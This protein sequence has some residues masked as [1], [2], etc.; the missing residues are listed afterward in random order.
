MRKI[1][2]GTLLVNLSKLNRLMER[3]TIKN[4]TLWKRH[5]I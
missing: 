4:N 3:R 1:V 5:P 2:K